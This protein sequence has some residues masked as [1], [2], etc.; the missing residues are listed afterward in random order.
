[1]ELLEKLKQLRQDDPYPMHMPGHK[2]ANMAFPDVYDI[3]ITEIQGYDNLHD[4][5]GIIKNL[6]DEV[7]EMYGADEAY[8]SVGGA[9]D[10]IL[11]A[12]FAA[13]GPGQRLLIARNSHK[14]VYHAAILRNADAV[15]A[16]P[17][18]K[19]FWYPG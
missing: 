6:S 1:M 18:I 17:D 19:E 10:M 15:Y 7:A 16:F 3:D 12:V 9:T 11:T 2:R 4:P 13:A 8:L 14:S 5:R